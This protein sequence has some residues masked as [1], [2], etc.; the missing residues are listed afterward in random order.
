MLNTAV[1]YLH[2]VA[3]VIRRA[4]GQLLLAQRPAH[5]HQGGKWE[6][7]GGKVEASETSYQALAR[8]LDEELGITTQTALP[9][10]KVR[11]HY[12]ERSVLLDVWEVTAFKGEPQ[13]REQQP[14]AWFKPETL[15][16][17]EFPPANYPII[18]AARL[19]PYYLITLEP[20]DIP[21][22]LTQLETSLVSGIKLIQFRAKTLDAKLY[23]ELA[24]QVIA[25]AQD[26]QAQVL[27]NS[28]PEFLP[29][30]AGLHLTS[31]QLITLKKRPLL[32]VGKWLAASCHNSIELAKAAQLN[33]D[34]AVLSPV[35]FT[36][37]HPQAETVGWDQFAKWVDTVNFPVY[38]LGGMQKNHA[39]IA[40][41]NGGQGI[42]A[43]R[44]LWPS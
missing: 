40:R 26:F 16:A 20:D 29:Q 15:T 34:F 33:V 24:L 18:N 32:P 43:I 28:P 5:K 1:D 31:Q 30:A 27:L 12:P 23:T 3:A 42:A 35:F 13:G 10:I 8:E 7:P 6:F 2:V 21:T 36:Q 4:D 39:K 11:Y 41:E 14:I 22:F 37:T 19:P 9:L 25:K 38:A 17:L 44:A